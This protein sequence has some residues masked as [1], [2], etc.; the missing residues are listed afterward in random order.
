M[1]LRLDDLYRMTSFI[2][3]DGNLGRSREATL[4][5]FVEVCGML[6]LLDRKKKRDR[7]DVPGALCKALGW[8]F[9]LLAKMGVESVERLLFTKYPAVCPYCR[10][11]PHAEQQCKL[12]KGTEGV[13]SHALVRELTEANWESRP[14]GLNDWQRMFADIYPRS[15]NATGGF[16]IIALLEELGELAE[17]IRVFDRYP[18]YFYGEAADV[19]SY[20]MGLANEYAIQCAE[21]GE[22]F[23]YELEFLSR[24]PGLCIACGGRVCI[25]PTVP[26]ATVGRMAK[27]MPISVPGILDAAKFD[28]AGRETA[29]KVLESIGRVP[30]LAKY[31]PYDRGDMNTALTQLAFRLANALEIDH[32]DTA[33]RLLALAIELGREKRPSGTVAHK[34]TA[35][36]LDVLKE[37]WLQA[38]PA[39]QQSIVIE[40]PE[41]GKLAHIL[42]T[43]VLIVTGNPRG[44]NEALRLDKEVSA[45]RLRVRLGAARDRIHIETLTAATVDS[46]RLALLSHNYDIIHFA[47]H[48]DAAGLELVGDDGVHNLTFDAFGKM[49]AGQETLKCVVLN[50]CSAMQGLSTAFAPLVIAMVDDIDDEEAIVFAKGFYDAVGAGQSPL[51]GFES[52]VTALESE[53][54]DP[55]LVA[56]MTR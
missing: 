24:Y 29:D 2:Y 11:S 51:K 54:L 53:G 22:T 45:I 33:D 5:H 19:F 38:D 3:H 17:A 16:S 32:K 56:K 4:L 49:L 37:A 21:R 30:A 14:T 9:P 12:V 40:Q 43:R 47:G 48:A 25:C 55:H 23:N 46:L 42:E 44:K 10:K 35:D 50:A 27:E 7:V 31:L 52:G 20:L 13:V 1:K 28:A 15:L 8:Y 34:I 36:I 18:H 39:V 41:L 6:T 26:P